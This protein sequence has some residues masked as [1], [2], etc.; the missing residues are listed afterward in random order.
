[1]YLPQVAF[2]VGWV[3]NMLAINRN[4]GTKMLAFYLHYASGFVFIEVK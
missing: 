4:V 1:M 3:S 2:S